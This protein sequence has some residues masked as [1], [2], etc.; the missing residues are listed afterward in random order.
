M[1]SSKQRC[2]HIL[3]YVV[4]SYPILSRLLVLPSATLSFLALPYLILSYPIL[5]CHILFYRILPYLVLCPSVPVQENSWCVIT[6]A[7]FATEKRSSPRARVLGSPAWEPSWSD[8]PGLVKA[9]TPFAARSVVALHSSGGPAISPDVGNAG[10]LKQNIS[11]GCFLQQV[12]L[13]TVN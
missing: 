6:D 4:V 9:R 8:R 5:F 2:Y 13:S 7:V 10:D 1:D 12:M 3:S 11:I